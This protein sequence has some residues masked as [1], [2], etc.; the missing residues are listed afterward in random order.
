LGLLISRAMVAAESAS[1]GSRTLEQTTAFNLQPITPSN[2]GR[3]SSTA[4]AARGPLTARQIGHVRA[5]LVED[6]VEAARSRSQ[7]FW[8]AETRELRLLISR[9]TR[10]ST[11]T[12]RMLIQL[13]N[14]LSEHTPLQVVGGGAH[15]N[16][17]PMQRDIG[18]N[19][20]VG[21]PQRAGDF[22]FMN[23]TKI[24]V[25][26]FT[27]RPKAGTAVF[28]ALNLALPGFGAFVG[29]VL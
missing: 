26:A 22:A 20:C 23:E 4:L 12:E 24:N 19:T 1:C 6:Q 28:F 2:R 13:S 14:H 9:A 3:P 7:R 18:S 27:R 21:A 25:L 29:R 11:M 8:S 15:T 10:S 16:R 17:T 5:P